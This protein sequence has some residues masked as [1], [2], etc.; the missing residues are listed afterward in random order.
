MSAPSPFVSDSREP[1]VDVVVVTYNSKTRIRACAE[2]G[3][4]AGANVIV[5][6]SHS[7]D[8]SLE[9]V[10]DLPVS[11]IQLDENRGF[12]YG[13]NRGWE[14]GTAPYVLFLNPDAILESD[15]LR[16]MAAALDH[17]PSIGAV[18]PRLVE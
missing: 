5:V 11:A 8:R 14:A 2:A 15:A 13:C 6:D 3:L 7:P 9:A 16:T 1:T 4:S 10:A 12:G 18:G 17:D